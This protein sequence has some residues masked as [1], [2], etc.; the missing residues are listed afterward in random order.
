M[1][2]ADR[3][4]SVLQCAFEWKHSQVPSGYLEMSSLQGAFCHRID[5]PGLSWQ[6]DSTFP[7]EE[8]Q[9]DMLQQLQGDSSRWMFF[10]SLC[11]LMFP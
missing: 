7:A 4:I 11:F 2:R 1:S 9:Q 10:C 8:A 6:E 5:V 3:F